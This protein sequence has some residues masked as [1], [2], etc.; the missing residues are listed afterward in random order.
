[1][2]GPSIWRWHTIP[3]VATGAV[4]PTNPNIYSEQPEPISIYYFVI[5]QVIIQL[6]SPSCWHLNLNYCWRRCS[7]SCR[8]LD[9]NDCRTRRSQEHMGF[10]LSPLLFAFV[11]DVPVEYF[12]S[13]F[14]L[15]DDVIKWKNFPRHWPF[16]RGIHRSP[17]NSPHKDQ[18]RGKCFHLMTS[19]LKWQLYLPLPKRSKEIYR[20]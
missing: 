12:T 19:S 2:R 14:D 6:Y 16:V 1:M 17:V 5:L 11:G 18:W 4:L 10:V 20:R 15:H 9:S 8:H 13:H 7:L 3:N